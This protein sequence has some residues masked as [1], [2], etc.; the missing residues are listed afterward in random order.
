MVPCLICKLFQGL[1]LSKCSEQSC[2]RG[3]WF[4]AFIRP[5]GRRTPASNREALPPPPPHTHKLSPSVSRPA[6]IIDFR[7]IP[8]HAPPPLPPVPLPSLASH[9]SM[10]V[11]PY[12]PGIESTLM[13]V[14]FP[15]LAGAL[16]I[17]Q[18]GPSPSPRPAYV[19]LPQSPGSGPSPSLAGV[20]CLFLDLEVVR[21]RVPTVPLPPRARAASAPSP[22]RA[23]RLSLA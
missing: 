13:V 22:F 9:A 17:W 21:A 6:P 15:S 12:G 5:G 16:M 3:R 19:L 23:R 18:L 7:V 14:P 11:A 8:A 20:W 2:V 10:D 1:V 4:G